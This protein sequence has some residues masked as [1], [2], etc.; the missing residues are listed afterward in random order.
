MNFDWI[1]T[2]AI[3][4]EEKSAIID[5]AK[6]TEWTY[7]QL[8]IRAENL[9][10]H[11]REQ[12][13]E[14]GDV[15]GIFAP[16][17]VA[18]LDV[19]FAS[20]KS[21]TVFLPINWRLNPEEIATVVEDSGVTKIFYETKHLSSLTKIDESLLYMD[22]NAQEYNDIVNPSHHNRFDS[23]ELQGD[24]LAALMYTSGTTGTPKGVMFTFESFIHNNITVNHTYPVYPTDIT[25]VS[26]PMFHVFGF[27]DLTLPV[28]FNGATLVLQRY[29]NAEELVDLMDQYKP[30]YILLIPTMYYAL[31]IAQNFK[32]E[33]FSNARFLIQGGSAPLPAVQAKFK[34]MGLNI[35]NGYGLTE[36]PLVSVNPI[37][38]A[39]V[40]PKSIGHP[41]IFTDIRIFDENFNEIETGG[42]G[43]L[44]V[45][46]K[47]VT[48]GYWNKPEAT[49]ESFHN[50]FF[51]TGDLAK[52]DEDGDIFI[53][54]RK[55]EMII[56]GGEN[57]LP[58]EVEAILSEHPLVAQCVVVGFT[59]PKYG[60]SVSA[61]VVLTEEDDN[62][63]EKLDKFAREKLGGY[64]V[65][66]MYLSIN[67]MPLNSTSKPDKLALQQR[68]NEKAEKLHQGDELA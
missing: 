14:R 33:V 20:I 51:L 50:D 23:V 10:N 52:V 22:I 16:N 27:N 32:P 35:I 40:K 58:S 29:F 59:S 37:N 41:A 42:I 13:T 4:E 1:K 45:R 65:P 19:L 66:R 21:G 30:N 67:H 55:K 44:A 46:G 26:L 60:E 36:A 6:G 34:S 43:E 49:A 62:F 28:L 53:V 11:L 18:I 25:I 57:V 3:F 61:A 68:M 54:D 64:K 48:P 63:E 9:A 31:L 5:P 17:D 47:N 15:I 24:D 38:N 39:I 7:Q 56:T 8:N 2:R 12:G